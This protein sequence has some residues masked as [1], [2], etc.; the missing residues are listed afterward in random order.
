MIHKGSCLCG[1]VRYEIHGELTGVL[2]CHCSDC[3]KAHGAAFRTR[4]TVRSKDFVWISGEELISRYEAAP[5]EF[6][7][8]CGVCGANLVTEFRTKPEVYGFALGTLDTDP[9]VKPQC[10]VFVSDGL[11]GMTSQTDFLSMLT[12][13]EDTFDIRS[14]SHRRLLRGVDGVICGHLCQPRRRVGLHT[15]H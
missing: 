14:C 15:L 7:T 9:G 8:F 1:K 2:N 10:H 12:D 13:H 5:S 4:G 3:R 6:R 11:P